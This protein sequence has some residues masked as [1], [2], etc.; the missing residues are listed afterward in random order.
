MCSIVK[1]NEIMS[2]LIDIRKSY[3]KFLGSSNA[4]RSSLK[5]VLYSKKFCCYLTKECLA[6]HI[7]EFPFSHPYRNNFLPIIFE[8]KYIYFVLNHL[9]EKKFRF[10]K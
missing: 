7:G 5:S 6:E 9:R 10:L 1:G 8:K 2:D 4:W 3:V